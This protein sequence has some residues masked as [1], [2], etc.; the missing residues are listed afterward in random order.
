MSFS[1]Q[2]E[3]ILDDYINVVSVRFNLQKEELKSLWNMSNQEKKEKKEKKEPTIATVDMTDTSIERLMKSSKA[4]L[5]AL[6]KAK[7]VKCSGKKEELIDRLRNGNEQP[8]DGAVPVSKSR[9]KVSPK[10]TEK[11]MA[12]TAIAQKLSKATSTIGLRKNDFNN[13]EHPETRLIFD[14][15]AGKVIGKQNDDGTVLSL[16]TNDIEL[17]KKFKF[18]YVLPDNLDRDNTNNVHIEELDEKSDI[19]IEDR[20][21]PVE[22]EEEEDEEEDEEEE[23][24]I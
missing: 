15:K 4:E 2:I 23:I 18:Q 17:C 22:I 8:K 9:P 10:K 19:V 12:N 1:Q 21:D 13:Y 11:I 20:D 14:E 6:C 5:T 3:R 16:T 7:G 24:E